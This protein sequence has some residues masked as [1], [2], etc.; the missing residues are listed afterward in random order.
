MNLDD[1]K[2]GTGPPILADWILR[3]Y[4]GYLPLGDYY[5]DPGAKFDSSQVRSA[6]EARI[7]TILLF[8]VF[9]ELKGTGSNAEYHIIAWAGYLLTAF[10]AHGN[11]A[12]I[13][14]HFTSV[15][16]EGLESTTPGSD[17]YLGVKGVFL[18]E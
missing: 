3:G 14:G 16:W 6:M 11:D 10:E 4:Q 2:G 15:V 8:P 9:D 12:T 1:E 17:P 7:G 18:I 13:E 5:S